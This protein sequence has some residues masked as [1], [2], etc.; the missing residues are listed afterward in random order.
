MGGVGLGKGVVH[1]QHL[2]L[3]PVGEDVRVILPHVV[4]QGG[5]DDERGQE[6]LPAGILRHVCPGDGVLPLLLNLVE[7]NLDVADSHHRVIESFGSNPG[8]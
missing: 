8:A 5:E 3:V 7:A 1:E 6:A 2:A 4:E